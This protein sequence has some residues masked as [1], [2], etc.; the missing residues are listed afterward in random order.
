[1]KNFKDY[2]TEGTSGREAWEKYFAGQEFETTIKKDAPFYSNEKERRATK[3]LSP[4]TKVR[5]HYST[6]LSN[7]RVRISVLPSNE[8]GFVHVDVLTKPGV[9]QSKF[10]LKPDQILSLM[11]DEARFKPVALVRELEKRLPNTG[12]APDVQEYLLNLARFEI[13]MATEKDIQESFQEIEPNVRRDLVSSV[14][15]DYLEVVGALHAFKRLRSEGVKEISLPVRGNEPLKD[16]D[17]IL[18]GNPERRIAFSAKIRGKKSNTLKPG[19]V[20]QSIENSA[21]GQEVKKSLSREFELANLLHSNNTRDGAKA[22]AIFLNKYGRQKIDLREFDNLSDIEIVDREYKY[23]EEIMKMNLKHDDLIRAAVGEVFYIK[24]DIKSNG[25][26]SFD[27]KQGNLI[28]NAFLRPKN[29]RKG[30]IKDKI[31]WQL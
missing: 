9:R 22:L 15:K 23:S 4:R 1:M 5:V 28:E 11:G 17:L 30:R 14:K 21:R 16:F 26:A 8:E 10:Q 31:G 7:N 20:V 24:G 12:L 3:K 25:L 29:T 2:I 18:N 13:G 27:I 19:L 6:E